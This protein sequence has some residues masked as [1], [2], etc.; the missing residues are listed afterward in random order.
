MRCCS[1]KGERKLS[2][3]NKPPSGG[4][5]FVDSP[6]DKRCRISSGDKGRTWRGARSFENSVRSIARLE[7]RMARMSPSP[8]IC[9]GT[10][11][12]KPIPSREIV[13][14]ISSSVWNGEKSQTSYF[15][16]FSFRNERTR[17][18]VRKL[19]VLTFRAETIA[20]AGWRRL[21][22]LV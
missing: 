19:A 3:P 17:V 9:K 14:S 20:Q 12:N 16:F 2:K 15:A 4:I 1:I 22:V 21:L 10:A 11:S 5:T 7:G 13:R 6:S 18:R 8:S